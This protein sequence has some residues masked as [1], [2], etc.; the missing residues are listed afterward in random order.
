MVKLVLFIWRRLWLLEYITQPFL[1]PVFTANEVN[2]FLM[3]AR[4]N[5]FTCKAQ[6]RQ[7]RLSKII[8]VLVVYAKSAKQI[9]I[10]SSEKTTCRPQTTR[11]CLSRQ[12]VVSHLSRVT[13]TLNL[14][15]Q[16]FLSD[17]GV[18]EWVGSCRAETYIR[19]MCQPWISAIN[20][21]CLSG[22]GGD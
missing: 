15:S 14:P 7:C 10:L 3:S 18:V 9:F 4:S 6:C 1:T 5:L 20:L 11:A 16:M 21:L 13:V 8:K 22:I 12:S 2:W 19:A 17:E